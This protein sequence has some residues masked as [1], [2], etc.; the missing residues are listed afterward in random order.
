MN[1]AIESNLPTPPELGEV[2]GSENNRLSVNSFKIFSAALAA[3]IVINKL[4]SN[5]SNK[6]VVF[7]LLIGV[8]SSFDLC[9]TVLTF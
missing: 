3:G 8:K 9:V 6:S 5:T 7:F 4:H 1:L 2:D